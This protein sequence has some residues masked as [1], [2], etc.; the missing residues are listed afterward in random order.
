MNSTAEIAPSGGDSFPA[1]TIKAIMKHAL[2]LES[3][4]VSLHK[5]VL[6]FAEAPLLY[7]S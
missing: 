5:L 7:C 3:G 1:K 2:S 6:C 4:E